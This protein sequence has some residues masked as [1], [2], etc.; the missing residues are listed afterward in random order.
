MDGSGNTKRRNAHKL[1]Y[2]ASTEMTM[3][4]MVMVDRSVRYFFFFLLFFTNNNNKRNAQTWL[5]VRESAWNVGIL[6]T[7]NLRNFRYRLRV[8]ATWIIL[9]Y[10]G[11]THIH[12]RKPFLAHFNRLTPPTR[13]LDNT[14]R[15]KLIA[16][17]FINFVGH[18]LR[19]S[20][21]LWQNYEVTIWVI[22]LHTSILTC[23]CICI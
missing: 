13:K 16:C 21:K 22:Y 9:W 6:Y 3:M 12:H 14:K 15:N 4:M 8:C 7:R 17:T 23:A 5:T 1:V 2:H 11:R 18:A 19:W 20:W 10:C